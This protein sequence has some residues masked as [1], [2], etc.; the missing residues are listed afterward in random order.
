MYNTIKE[1]FDAKYGNNY[2]KEV[3]ELS[4]SQEGKS[5]VSAD[6]LAYSFDDIF[7]ND[8]KTQKLHPVDAVVPY[9]DKLI[10]IEFKSGFEDKVN[11]NTFKKSLYEE[12]KHCDKDKKDCQKLIAFLSDYYQLFY[13]KRKSQKHELIYSLKLKLYDVVFFV[14]NSIFPY[15]IQKRK[16]IEIIYIIVVDSLYIESRENTISGVN[17]NSIL[18][19]EKSVLI[20]DKMNV[21]QQ[22]FDAENELL[23]DKL[24]VVTAEEFLKQCNCEFNELG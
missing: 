12:S 19:P 9:E 10:L 5:L 17:K 18:T 23:C 7:K 16:D 24:V 14:K 2:K 13:E 1:Y 11:K 6:F 21:C 20:Q 3:T 4:K 8:K 22:L 15:C